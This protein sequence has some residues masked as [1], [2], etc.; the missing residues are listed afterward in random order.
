[1]VTYHLAPDLAEPMLGQAQ[2]LFTHRHTF[3]GT[4]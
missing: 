2:D 3:R 1:M 4:P